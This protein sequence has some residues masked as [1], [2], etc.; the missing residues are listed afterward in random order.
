MANEAGFTARGSFLELGLVLPATR[1]QAG[2]EGAAV[3]AGLKEVGEMDD[4]GEISVDVQVNSRIDLKTGKTRKVVGSSNAN[5][6]TITGALVRGD[7]GQKLA[8][9]ARRDG[10]QVVFCRNYADGGKEWGV[11]IITNTSRPIGDANSFTGFSV[12]IDPDGET[13]EVDPV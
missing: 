2:F 5:A 9:Q 6:M 13:V 3:I 4:L 7:E 11:G 10:V 12:T 1:D 8:E